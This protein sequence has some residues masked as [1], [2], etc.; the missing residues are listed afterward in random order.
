MLGLD[1]TCLFPVSRSNSDVF[2]PIP[3]DLKLS[4]LPRKNSEPWHQLVHIWL[5]HIKFVH[6]KFVLRVFIAT[7]QFHWPS[8]TALGQYSSSIGPCYGVLAWASTGQPG[9]MDVF[10]SCFSLIDVALKL[11]GCKWKIGGT[12]PEKLFSTCSGSSTADEV[13]VISRR[14]IWADVAAHVQSPGWMRQAGL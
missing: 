9:S 1:V 7:S 13:P 14:L 12:R 2:W 5:V 11:W 4:H 8:W 3:L 6:I 10:V